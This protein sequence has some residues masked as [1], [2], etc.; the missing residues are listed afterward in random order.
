MAARVLLT[1][2]AFKRRDPLGRLKGRLNSDFLK[3]GVFYDVVTNAR[4]IGR[5]VKGIEA[6]VFITEFAVIRILNL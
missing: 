2:G 1:A 4:L 6:S 3:S 5:V